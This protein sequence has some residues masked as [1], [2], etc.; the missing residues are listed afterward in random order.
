MLWKSAMTMAE[1]SSLGQ[2]H[3]HIPTHSNSISGPQK[4]SFRVTCLGLH[5]FSLTNS[6]IPPPFLLPL[7][8]TFLP[9]HIVLK[10]GT[11]AQESGIN[12]KSLGVLTS[13]ACS[14]ILL[15]SDLTFHTMIAGS[16]S[17]YHLRFAFS[18]AST[19]HPG[20]LLRISSG[21]SGL[22]TTCRQ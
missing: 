7:L 9:A 4:L 12:V 14:S 5:H 11:S 21:I 17:L 3:R 20:R 2:N 18:L 22:A 13:A 6:T 1:V 16:E 10:L 8:S 15:P 19:L